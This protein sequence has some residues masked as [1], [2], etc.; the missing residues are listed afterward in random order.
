MFAHHKTLTQAAK[1]IGVS[2]ITLRRWFLTKKI[3]EVGRDRNGWRVFSDVD[4][5]RIKNYATK[6]TPPEKQ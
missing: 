4:V 2:P 5:A 3:S 1:E 6:I